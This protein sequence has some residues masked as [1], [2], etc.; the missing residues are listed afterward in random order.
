MSVDRLPE[1]DPDPPAEQSGPCDRCG[2][3]A[4]V[5]IGMHVLCEHHGVMCAAEMLLDGEAGGVPK[6][7]ILEAYHV[8]F[9]WIRD[10]QYHLHQKGIL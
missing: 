8:M 3:D 2:A 5:A 6:E 9:G 1:R 7:D 4:T 10:V